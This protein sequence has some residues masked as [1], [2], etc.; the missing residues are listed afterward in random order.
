MKNIFTKLA[1]LILTAAFIF[2]LCSCKGNGESTDEPA[3]G[4]TENTSEP[5]AGTVYYPPGQEPVDR[6]YPQG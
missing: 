5:A 4:E 1:A 2:T 3:K 6:P